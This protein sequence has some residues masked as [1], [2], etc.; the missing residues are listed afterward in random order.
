MQGNEIISAHFEEMNRLINPLTII[1]KKYDFFNNSIGHINWRKSSI[2]NMV[3]N[4]YY[5]CTNIF[6]VNLE[7]FGYLL[8]WIDSCDILQK[9]TQKFIFGFIKFQSTPEMCWLQI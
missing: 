2:F 8:L 9:T 4:I 3:T 5:M 7:L 6:S 1:S